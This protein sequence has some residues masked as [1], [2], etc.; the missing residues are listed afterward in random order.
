MPALYRKPINAVIA[1]R[2]KNANLLIT[3]KAVHD[4]KF[5]E[6]RELEN[7]GDSRGSVKVWLEITGVNDDYYTKNGK[8]DYSS[9][10]YFKVQKEEKELADKYKKLVRE[11]KR[12]VIAQRRA[13]VAVIRAAL[14]K[15]PVKNVKRVLK[16]VK[17]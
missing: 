7:K 11:R 4:K 2:K 10:H 6:W 5:V 8:T 12:G 15:S 16:L 9:P 3:Q 17:K 13:R 14:S 1:A